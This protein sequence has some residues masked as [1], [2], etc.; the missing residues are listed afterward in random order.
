MSTLPVAGAATLP[1]DLPRSAWFSVTGSAATK[2][3]WPWRT[4]LP[5]TS[6]DDVFREVEAGH[7][8]YAVVPVENSTEGAVAAAWTCFTTPLKILAG[9]CCASIRN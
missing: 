5:Q 3:F 2:H 6:I 4:L 1:G 9:H 8:H 7:A